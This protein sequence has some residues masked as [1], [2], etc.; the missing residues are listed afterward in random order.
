MFQSC[1][2]AVR[3]LSVHCCMVFFAASGL[4]VNEISA[5]E[6]ESMYKMLYNRIDSENMFESRVF[7]RILLLRE[8]VKKIAGVFQKW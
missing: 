7:D 1:L 6:Q 2:H 4:H 5:S 3:L 8:A